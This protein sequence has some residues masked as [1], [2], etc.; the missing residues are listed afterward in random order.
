MKLTLYLSVNQLNCWYEIDN[1]G[2]R[3]L[4]RNLTLTDL[5]QNEY[6]FDYNDAVDDEMDV[7]QLLMDADL[8]SILQIGI[9]EPVFAGICGGVQPNQFLDALLSYTV[10][11]SG[12][13]LFN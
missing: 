3:N 12:T 1:E 8:S 10:I 5:A 6:K 11:L 4:T 13:L 9:E 7:I 2:I